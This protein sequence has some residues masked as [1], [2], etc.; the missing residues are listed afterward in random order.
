MH[1]VH[2]PVTLAQSDV[3]ERRVKLIA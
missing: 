1:L 2:E 3:E